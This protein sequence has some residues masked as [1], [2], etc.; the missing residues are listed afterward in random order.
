MSSWAELCREVKSRAAGRCEYCRMHESLQGAT[1]HVE[2]IV[3]RAC[4]GTSIS[5]NLALACPAC[6][7]SKSDRVDGLDPVTNQ[8]VRIFNPRIDD[9][10]QHFRWDGFEVVGQTPEGRATIS[11]LDLNEARR[12]LIRQAEA[13]FGLFPGCEEHLP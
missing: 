3:P 8:R 7:L 11:L 13:L 2:H 9:W 10:S 6:N 4:G 5:A 1:F 12:L